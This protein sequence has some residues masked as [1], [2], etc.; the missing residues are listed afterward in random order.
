M[1]NEKFSLYSKYY[2]V[3]YLDKNYLL[4]VEYVIDLLVKNNVPGKK[5]VE[6]GCGTGKHG[7][8]LANHGYHVHGVDLSADM[9]AQAAQGNGFTCEQGNILNKKIDSKFDAI[10]SMFHVVSYQTENDELELLF[11]NAND[12]LRNGGLFIFDVWYTPAVYSQQPTTRVKRVNSN[13]IEV[14]RIA[15]PTIYSE[16]NCVAVDYTVYLK[17]ISTGVIESF[18]ESH[19]LRHFSVPEIKFLAQKNG[20]KVLNSEEF[21]S[22]NKL[23]TKT[24]GACFILKKCN[25][26]LYT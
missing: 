2:D 13:S 8:L 15:E 7:S 22:K 3:L 19:L 1:K 21:L 6:W 14:T 12:H 17:D 24:W 20:F 4:E 11:I 5:I 9:I 18:S 23:S 26:N 10:I 25:D 16:R